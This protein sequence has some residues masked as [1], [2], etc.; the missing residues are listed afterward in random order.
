MIVA[1]LIIGIGLDSRGWPGIQAIVN[2]WVGLF[3]SWVV[4][5]TD[6]LERRRLLVCCFLAFIGEILLGWVWGLYRYRLGNLPMFIPPGHAL[7]YAAGSRILPYVPKWLP[8]MV[9]LSLAPVCVFGALRGYDTQGPVWYCII[10]LFFSNR[11]DNCFYAGMFVFALLIEIY[12]TSL[13]GWRYFECEPLL[14]L[15]TLTKPPLWTGVFYCA[16]DFVLL[17]VTSFLFPQNDS[18]DASKDPNTSNQPAT[19]R[20]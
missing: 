2:L 14:G 9:G 13:G 17:R 19:S 20:S 18:T 7:V 1:T 11:E 16:L 15:C 3:F 6:Q 5:S 8:L 10:L 4:W 12:G